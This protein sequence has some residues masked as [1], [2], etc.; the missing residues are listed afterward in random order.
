MDESNEIT[1][2]RKIGLIFGIGYRIFGRNGWYWGTSL[3]GG[4]YF[5]NTEFS[6][7]G[8]GTAGSKAIIDGELLKIGKTF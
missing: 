2:V 5:T 6:I 4:R 3:F 7:S 1:S 8:A